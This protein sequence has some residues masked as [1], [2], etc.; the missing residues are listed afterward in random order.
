MP[1][2]L[3]TQCC[4]VGGGPAGM[5]LGFLLA[6]AG[7]HTLVLEKHN[8]FLRDFRGDTIHPSTLENIHELGLLDEF[9]QR[10]HQKAHHVRAMI[11]DTALSFADLSHLPTVC[12]FIAFMPQWE[13]L[14]FLADRARTLPT[15]QL[16][17][18]AEVHDVI[19]DCDTIRGVRAHTPDGPLDVRTALTVG[20][21]GR[22]STVREK[23]GLAVRTLGAPIDVLWLRLPH[24]AGDSD[25]PLGRFDRGR[26][27]IMLYRGEYWQCGFVIPKGQWDG[28]R[29]AGI[30]AFRESIV[31][32]APTFANRVHELRTWDDVKLL[33]VA[34]DR[35]A[36]WYKPGLLCIGDAAHAMSPVG[37]VGINLAIQDA[38]A[39]ANQLAVK[40][41]D[42]RVRPSDL[43]KVQRR[44]L[45]PTQVTQFLQVQAQE[46]ILSRVLSSR[47]PLNPAMIIRVLNWFPWLRRIPARLIGVG[48][49]PEHI[50]MPNAFPR[51]AT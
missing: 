2:V 35:L 26:I 47:R 37:G 43:A 30:E 46:R 24:H 23:A 3:Q 32:I 11:G 9:L 50:H 44:R 48:V 17:M 13:F 27:F 25:Q 42:D 29:D 51:E 38:V 14:N 8:D 20:C 16:V 12:R 15:F 5:M 4:I 28:I 40:L 31:A 6:R 21:D 10:P 7:V 36:K 19:R 41:R 22:K 49:R 34:V 1:T 18:N 39:A 33:T 45:F